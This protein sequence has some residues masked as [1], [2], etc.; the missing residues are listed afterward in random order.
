VLRFAVDLDDRRQRIAKRTQA[1]HQNALEFVV[2][3]RIELAGGANL[4]ALNAVTR[5]HGFF[6]ERRDCRRILPAFI[7]GRPYLFCLIYE[8]FGGDV[9]SGGNGSC[10]NRS[11]TSNFLA[12][13]SNFI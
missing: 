4:R 13:I 12:T 2:S 11:A 10:A 3:H 8:T 6:S 7:C 9:G 1:L 5:Q